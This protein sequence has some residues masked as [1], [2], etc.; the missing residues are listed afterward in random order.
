MHVH[1][2]G[3]LEVRGGAAAVARMLA[4][5]LEA[6]GVPVTRGFEIADGG[7]AAGAACGPES[8]HAAAPQDALVHVHGSEDFAACLSG[9]AERKGRVIVTLHDCKLFTAGCA[10]PLDCRGW[11]GSC[12]DC[13]RGFGQG[14]DKVNAVKEMI[15]R[16]DPLLIAPS[17][18]M[19]DLAARALP[20]SRIRIL[21][22]GVRWPGSLPDKRAA[23]RAA[24][25]DPE[26]RC[27][28][29]AAHGGVRAAYKSG[30]KWLDIWNE[31]NASVPGVVGF[32]AG[33]ERF[34]RMGDLLVW[35]YLEEA[36]LRGLMRAADILAYPARA[37]NHPLIVL[38]AMSEGTAV[39]AFAV[40]GVPEQI[41][42][43][44]T[45]FLA[46]EGDWGVFGHKLAE[47]VRR[48]VSPRR[49]G[50]AAFESGRERFSAGRM[51]RDHLRLYEMLQ[52]ARALAA[53]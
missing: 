50:R 9:L 16:L 15:G 7:A 35:P 40:G 6:S 22:N 14:P 34:E 44:G 10:Y 42:D 8:V 51:V 26:A 19:A 12:A 27:V 3:L 33:G 1:L 53:S 32:A 24:G 18:W 21:P 37:D 46:P 17:R 25:L 20:G 48:P 30:D 28:M 45:G 23:K 36:A 49:A 29:F 47:L 52:E 4:A 31:L 5:G 41:A 2:H 43:G 11:R 39:L 13:P 38:E